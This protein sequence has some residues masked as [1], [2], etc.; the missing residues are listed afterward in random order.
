MKW[1]ESVLRN[2]P[3]FD[4]F[5]CDLFTELRLVQNDLGVDI[6]ATM[7]WPLGPSLITLRCVNVWAIN[8]RWSASRL[9][10]GE[11]L[12]CYD[13]A[14]RG[15]IVSDE[16]VKFSWKCEDIELVSINHKCDS[17]S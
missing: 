8:L 6:L 13:E 4:Q 16:L 5:Q 12:V 10:I 1:L 17:V 3:D 14:A 15:I 2:I 11:L 7:R 9:E